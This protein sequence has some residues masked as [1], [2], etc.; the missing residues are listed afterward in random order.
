MQVSVYD[1]ASLI[2]EYSRDHYYD[3]KVR[4]DYVVETKNLQDLYTD[5]VSAGV[6]SR[7]GALSHFRKY[8]KLM[9]EME[10]NC[11]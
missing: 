7:A 2:Y 11:Y 3:E 5:L 10:S 4:W 6:K 1:L 8:C 9:E